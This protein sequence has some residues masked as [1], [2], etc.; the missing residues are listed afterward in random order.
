M[1]TTMMKIYAIITFSLII[2]ST[3]KASNLNFIKLSALRNQHEFIKHNGGSTSLYVNSS[4]R[5]IDLYDSVQSDDISEIGQEIESAYNHPYKTELFLAQRIRYQKYIFE[6][7]AFESIVATINNPV[8][9]ELELFSVRSDTFGVQR[10]FEL[11]KVK[12]ITKLS[13]SNRW[14]IDEQFSLEEIVQDEVEVDLNNGKTYTPIYFDIRASLDINRNNFSLT[15]LGLDL[16]NKD[17]FNYFTADINYMRLL[18]R[19]LSIG[20]ILSP[21]FEGNYKIEETLGIYAM[22][23]IHERLKLELKYTDLV[24]SLNSNLV[25]KHF[26]TQLGWER[27]RE[28]TFSDLQV[29]N[30]YLKLQLKY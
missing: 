28:S 20:L 19:Y 2:T 4:Q 7:S 6:V 14:Y 22:V 13:I 23:N 9:P 3:V 16:L 10:S 21:V 24:S 8:F 25:F 26:D 1:L 18:N 12:L 5:F 11:D 17:R 27:V 30:L 15:V 29:S